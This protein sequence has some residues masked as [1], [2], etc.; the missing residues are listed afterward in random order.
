MKE[1]AQ[2]MR[3][4]QKTANGRRVFAMLAHKHDEK[5]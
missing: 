1:F 2:A 4:L 5:P 3:L